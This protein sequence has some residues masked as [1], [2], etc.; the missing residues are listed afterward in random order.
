MEKVQFSACMKD[1]CIN[2]LSAAPCTDVNR[3]ATESRDK[4]DNAPLFKHL[5]INYSM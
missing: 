5:F 4:Q 1:Y 2:L 3:T